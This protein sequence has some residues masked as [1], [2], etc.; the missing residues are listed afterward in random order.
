MSDKAEKI[1]RYVRKP[2]TPEQRQELA[3][4]ADLPDDQID[5]SDIPPLTDAF[6]ENAVRGMFYRPLK[7]QLTLR[8]DADLIEWFKS[9]ADKGKGYQ[10]KI[11]QALREYVAEQEKKAG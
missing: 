10:T 2:L 6:F 9:H 3:A 11:N 7:K 4:L 8:I 5:F 1:V